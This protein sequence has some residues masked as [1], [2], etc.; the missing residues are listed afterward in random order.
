LA[1]RADLATLGTQVTGIDTRVKTLESA[2]KV[3]FGAQFG[4]AIGNFSVSGKTNFDIDR[5]TFGTFLPQVNDVTGVDTNAVLSAFD[6]TF[7]LK[8]SNLTT[9]NGLLVVSDATIDFG[10]VYPSYTAVSGVATSLPNLLLFKDA[11]INGKLAGSPFKVVY[12]YQN[13]VFRFNDYLFRDDADPNILNVRNGAVV[14][15]AATTLPFSPN[16]TIVAGVGSG[17]VLKGQY[18]GVRAEINPAS[19]GKFGLNFAQNVNNR[20]AAGIDANFKIGAFNLRGIYDVSALDNVA[21]GFFNGGNK[22]GYIQATADLKIARIAANY[23]GIDPTYANGVAGM[24]V[25]D[26]YYGGL[27]AYGANQIGYGA[28]LSTT[29]GPVT[30]AAI[31]DHRTDYVNTPGSS[32]TAFGV[33][34]GVKIFSLNLIGFYNNATRTTSITLAHTNGDFTYNSTG[35]YQGTAFVPF[36]YSST[37]GA[38]LTHNGAAQDALIKGL[39]FTIA[40]AYFYGDAIND[41]QAYGSYLGTVAGL[42]VNPFARYHAFNV[43]GNDGIT[44]IL[45]PNGSKKFTTTTMDGTE[46]RSYTA[47]KYGLKVSSVPLNIFGKPSVA[48]SF[49]NAV[50]TPGN[51]LAQSNVSKTE[52][53]AQAVL[54]LNDIGLGGLVPSIGY[55]YYQGFNIPNANVGTAADVFNTQ[56]DRLYSDPLGGDGNPY[57]GGNFGTASGSTRGIFAGLNYL[58]IGLNY[59]MFYYTDFNN[60]ANNT[61]AQAFRIGYG[62]RF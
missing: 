33:A 21:G 51:T 7:G 58:G 42:T 27:A 30:T 13:S 14:S 45:R 1:T 5:T 25:S 23:R 43:P 49:A 10:I 48:L 35:A 41:F 26:V 3:S 29:L 31:G 39:N 4:I 57:N 53:F 55:G 44:P 32:Q 61:T 52:L 9:A 12:D 40:D 22:A 38:T 47:V 28:A 60:A 16:L 46:A 34:A 56:A 6:F 62:F 19:L 18:F 15:F 17:P 54:S 59:G 36:F 11:A 20:T 2:P 50:T 24:S 8:A 37:Y